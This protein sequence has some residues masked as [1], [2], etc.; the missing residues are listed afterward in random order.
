MTKPSI[1]TSPEAL[2]PRAL[3]LAA[4]LEEWPRRTVTLTE[5]WQVF[6]GAGPASA[7][8]PT[9]RAELADAIQA[10]EAAHLIHPSRARDT[11]AMPSL[12]TRV[13]LPA[14]R[15]SPTASALARTVPWRPELAWAASAR[16]TLGQLDTLQQV[17][18]WLRDRG[19]DDDMAP[20]RERSLE[21]CG[22]EKRLD[23]LRKTS[24]FSPDRLSLQL[25]RT[26]RAHP[27]LSARRTGEGPVL[28]VVENA[29]TFDTLT[30]VLT[31]IPGD[32]GW[33]AWGAGAGFEA[34]ILS[35]ADL[36]AVRSIA[37]FGDLDADG[38]RIPASAAQTASQENL[39]PVRPATG[40]Y[41]LLLAVGTPQAG[42]TP[43]PQEKA[44]ELAGWL[45]DGPQAAQAAKL[46]MGGHRIA[47]E[48]VSRRTLTATT[49]GSQW[50]DGLTPSS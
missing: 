38:L 33:V 7:T 17:N 16:L 18:N 20:L 12:P 11:T 37:Y 50:R 30:R 31:A 49:V 8:R 13:T 26:F 41:R 44:V 34:S 10:L 22:N 32:I 35:T 48:A 29:D 1:T 42:Q 5:L 21:I 6:A 4:A 28:L 23:A 19:R 36:T 43:L 45:N 27:P 47:Q 24:L 46:L 39:P 2:P 14:P 40:L 15:P 3:H 25:L 9:R